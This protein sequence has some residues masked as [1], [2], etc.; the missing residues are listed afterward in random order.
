M[1]SIS[2]RKTSRMVERSE[3]RICAAKFTTEKGLKLEDDDTGRKV[4][5]TQITGYYCHEG[6]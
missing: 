6:R 1:M 4:G 5:M 2:L 3:R